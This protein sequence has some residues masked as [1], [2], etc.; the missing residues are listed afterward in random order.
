[1]PK[2]DSNT[3][4]NQTDNGTINNTQ[5]Q[6]QINDEHTDFGNIQTNANTST[7][8][9]THLGN[10]HKYLYS[11]SQKKN[12]SSQSGIFRQNLYEEPIKTC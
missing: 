12:K 11:E 5:N 1:M 3:E 6:T 4:D 8:E 10:K 9:N 2:T 7:T